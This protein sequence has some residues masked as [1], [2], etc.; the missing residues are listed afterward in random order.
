MIMI[1]CEKL[2]SKNGNEAFFFIR[3]CGSLETIYEQD[4]ELKMSLVKYA[5]MRDI[6][7]HSLLHINEDFDDDLLSDVIEM[8]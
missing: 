8:I 2:C 4:G 3:D 5:E 1:K 7:L 6:Y